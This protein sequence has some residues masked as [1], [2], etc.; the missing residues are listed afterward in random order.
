MQGLPGGKQLGNQSADSSLR[1]QWFFEVCAREVFSEVVGSVVPGQD[2]EG[3][4]GS[5]F[6]VSLLDMQGEDKIEVQGE[7][8]MQKL[9]LIK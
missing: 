2:C 7:G 9:Q 5:F 6:V 3:E 1:L 4:E 8:E